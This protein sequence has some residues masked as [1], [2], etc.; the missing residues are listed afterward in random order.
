MKHQIIISEE[1]YAEIKKWKEGHPGYKDY[2][3]DQVFESFLNIGFYAY[4]R[5]GFDGSVHLKEGGDFGILC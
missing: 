1:L 2:D 5:D 3:L 4:R